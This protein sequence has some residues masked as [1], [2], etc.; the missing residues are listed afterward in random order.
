MGQGVIQA[1]RAGREW[2]F[3]DAQDRCS[4]NNSE[5]PVDHKYPF[6]QNSL[7]YKGSVGEKGRGGEGM[8]VILSIFF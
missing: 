8:Y 4:I 2:E 7:V 1:A 6:P 3:Q 5:H